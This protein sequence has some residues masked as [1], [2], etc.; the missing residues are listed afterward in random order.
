MSGP[1][2]ISGFSKGIRLKSVPGS[3]TRP[4]A[5]KVKESL[6]NIIGADIIESSFLDLFGGT[7]SVG[8]EALSRG[9]KIT[10]FIEKNNK[11]Y[12]VLLTNLERTHL[13]E[14][15]D[16]LFLDAFV[17]LKKQHERVFDYIYIA[18]PQYRN[19]WELA[20]RQL[21]INDSHLSE[22]GW[23]IAQIDPVEEKL[24]RLINFK[25]FDKRKYGNT[26]LLFFMRR[27]E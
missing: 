6:F 18:P 24:I 19:L 20:L 9:A 11:A 14:N 8:I 26:E 16:V 23:I 10:R 7:G 22:D 27:F 4:I 25:L 17:Y 15:A 12:Q 3:T 2:I 1:R 13:N 21:D 5:D